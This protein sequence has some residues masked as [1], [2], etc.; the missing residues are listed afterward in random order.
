MA[1]DAIAVED[2][3]YPYGDLVAVDHIS[4]EVAEGEILGFLGPNGAGK[5][6]TVKML[7]GQLRP[8]GGQAHVLGMD[9]ARD[10]GKVRGEIGVCFEQ[11]NLY[12]QMSALDN[13]MLFAELFG[14]ER[15]RRLCPAETRRA[16]RAGEGQSLRLF[17][18]HEAA[19]DGG[20]VAGQHARKS[21]SWTSLPPG[22]T[23]FRPRPSATSSWKSATAAPLS[24]SPRTIC[25][26][27]TSSADRV[28]FMNRGKIAALDTPHNL[29]QQY[30]KRSLVAEV[31]GPDGD[32][33]SGRSALDTPGYRP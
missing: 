5:T 9:V 27:R 11:T 26:K 28:A 18:G 6:T 17:Q 21:S 14:V 8:K 20:A 30:G 4:F 1:G 13:L 12:E 16:G 2:L 33:K 32:W 3:V 19:P 25:G 31:A 15:I 22:W 7:T 24:S 23:R 29:K 10:A